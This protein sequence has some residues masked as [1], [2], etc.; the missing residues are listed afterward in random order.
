[1][2]LA[3]PLLLHRH[4]PPSPAQFDPEDPKADDEHYDEVRDD[5]LDERQE[6]D[7]FDSP[8]DSWRE[9]EDLEALLELD[10]EPTGRFH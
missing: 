4:M 9:L 7:L 3:Q 5:D 10:E 2:T 1:M 8:S 6:R